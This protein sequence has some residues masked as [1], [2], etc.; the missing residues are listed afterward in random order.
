MSRSSE[1]DRQE[2]LPDCPECGHN[3]FVRDYRRGGWYCE[4]CRES[5]G[6]SDP[7]PSPP[8]S[9]TVLV[10]RRSKAG[11]RSVYHTTDCRYVKRSTMNE[12]RREVAEAWDYHECGYC[13]QR[14]AD[15][16]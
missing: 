10:C 6:D 5:W 13:Q 1:I 15:A 2:S 12:W 16:E 14:R 3:A 11:N 9:E 8:T 4:S 7:E